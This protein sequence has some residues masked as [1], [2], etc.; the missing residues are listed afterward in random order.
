MSIN[1]RERLREQFPFSSLGAS[2][3]IEGLADVNGDGKADLIF[4]KSGSGEMSVVLLNGL[5]IIG[6]GSPGT[7]ST[8]WQVQN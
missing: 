7:V 4:L 5:A 3:F 8:D 6:S 2:W 1:F